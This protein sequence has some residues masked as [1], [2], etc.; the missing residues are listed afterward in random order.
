MNRLNNM[1]QRKETLGVNFL[2][3]LDFFWEREKS[4]TK[5]RT[6]S[7]NR[8]QCQYFYDPHHLM[9][10]FILLEKEVVFCCIKSSSL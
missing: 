6:V 8:Q 9:S 2:N 3:V 7:F 5:K 1:S 10:D 4:T